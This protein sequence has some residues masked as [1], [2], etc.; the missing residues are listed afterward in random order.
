MFIKG[1]FLCNSIFQH[2]LY[3]SKQ[4]FILSVGIGGPVTLMEEVPMID[5][6]NATQQL[7]ASF[8]SH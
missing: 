2:T 7:F 4:F 5:E 1:I 8:T 3:L 6:V